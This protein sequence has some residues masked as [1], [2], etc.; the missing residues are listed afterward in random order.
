MPSM[1]ERWTQGR[2]PIGLRWW[3][4]RSGELRR[5]WPLPGVEH[6]AL[7]I[8]WIA[9]DAPVGVLEHPAPPIDSGLL[10]MLDERFPNRRWFAGEWDTRVETRRIAA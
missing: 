6:A 9:R 2:V 8:G 7:A 10:E 5:G 3:I 4:T 1:L